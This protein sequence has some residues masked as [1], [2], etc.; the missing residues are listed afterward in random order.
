[1]KVNFK[2]I[3]K[4]LSITIASIILLLIIVIFSLRIPAVQNFAKGHLITFLE[5]KIQTKVT[6][7]KVYVDFP[8]NI[9]IKNLYLQGQDVDTL[10]YVKN[11]DAGLDIWQL[12]KN[13]VDINSIDLDGVR[14]N[15]VRKQDG[16]FNF[17]YIVNAFAAND[18][19]EEKDSKPFIF[20]LDKVKIQNVDVSFIDKQAGNNI[21]VAFNKFDTRVKTF[22]LEKNDYAIGDLI[23]D[24]LKLKL[25][26]DLVKEVAKKVEEKVDSLNQKQPMKIGLKGIQLSNFDID[27]GDD[28]T[29]LFAQLNFK[30]FKTTIKKL[31]LEKN[32]YD[33]GDIDLNGLNLKFNQNLVQDIQNQTNDKVDV[34]STSAPLQLALNKINLKDINVEYG[35]ENVKMYAKVKLNDFNTIIRKLD[36]EQS[37]YQ[38]GDINLDGLDAV[39]N[40]KVVAKKSTVNTSTSKPL[41]IDLNKLNLTNIKVDY[42]DESSRTKAKVDV[43]DLKSKINK[44]DLSN[45]IFDIDH[46][47]LKSGNVNANLH[48]ASSNSNTTSSSSNPISV[49]LKK[50]ILED[51]K[52]NYNNTAVRP[53]N[54]G[55][56]YN[57]LKFSKL[58]V[59]VEYFKMANN[60]FTGSVKKAEIKESKGLNVEQLKT[61]FFY[62]E[63]Q[64]YLKN[65]FLQTPRTLLRDQVILSYQSMKQLTSNPGNIIVDAN[66]KNSKIGFAD[67]LM[68]APT[69]RSTTPFNKY[70]NGILNVDTK[71]NGKVNDF[72]IHHLNVSGLDDLKLTA[73][74]KVLNAMNPDKL[75]FDVNIKNFSTSSKTIYN[76]VPK[77]TIPS[78]I[79]IPS[80]LAVNGKAK[81]STTLVNTQ[82]KMTSTLGN[83][84]LDANIDMRKKDAEKFAVKADLK[85]LDVGTIISN[86]ELGKISGKVNA[87]GTSFNPEKMN[88]E[89]EGLI[90]TATYNKYTYKNVA[91]D[92]KINNGVFNAQI[93]SD[94][95]NANLNLI[96][97]GVYKK[98]ITDV[99]LDGDITK[100]DIQKLGFYSSPMIIK[101][102]INA[103]FANLN[104]DALNGSLYLKDVAISDTKEIFPVQE[105]SLI[106]KATADSNQIN[107]TSQIA[108][109]EI[110]GRF[111]LTQIFGAVAQTI[112]N[113]YNF[114]DNNNAKDK[115][116]PHQYFT[117][118]AKIKDDDLIRKFVPELTNFET[119]T[120]NANYSS[121]DQIIEADATIPN[122]TYG[123]NI[124][125]KGKL[126]I[127]NVNNALVYSLN[128][129][130]I[131]NESF[132]LK[133]IDIE[134]DVANNTIKYKAS[135][136]DDKD[137]IQFLV[138]GNVKLLDDITNISLN[139]DGLV[140]NYNQ[141][142]VKDG[143]L[144][145]L[146]K[147]GIVANNFNISNNGSE[148]SLQSESDKGSSPLNINIK[149]FKIETITELIKKQDLPA[150]GII[151][152]TATIKDLN[153]EMMFNSDL[154]VTELNAF[155]NPVGN[156]VVK[157]Q[158]SSPSVI[159][160]DISL[161]GNNNDLQIKGDYNTKLSE[162]DLLV[163]V[164][165]LEMKTVQ[166]FAMNAIKDTEG[167]ISGKL[168]VKGTLEKPSIL[169]K[170]QFN[171]VGM[172]VA[173]TGSNFRKIS[174]AINFTPKGMELNQ[175]KINDADGNTLTINGNVLTETYR[176]FGFDLTANAR[177]FKVVNS[178][179]SRD[180]MMYGVL[181]VNA[182][183]NIKGNLDLPQVDGTLK[184][185][186][187]T[188]FTFVLPQSSP[189]LEEREGIVEFID[190]DQVELK[191][192]IKTD[193]LTSETKIKGYDVNVNIEIDREAKTSIIIDKA[194]GDFVEI[195][196]EAQLTGGMDPSGKTTLVGVYQVEKGAYELSVSLLKRRFDIQK[197]STI[198]WTGEPTTAQLNITALYKTEAAPIDLIVQQVTG[199]SSSEMNKYKQ[200]IPFNTNLILKG[201]LL[202]PEIKFGITL[203]DDNPTVS[204]SVVDN[205]KAKL[206]QLKNDEAEMNKQVFALLLLNRFI[207]E[208]P[209]KSQSGMSAE[210]IA[211]QSVSNI[212]SQQINNLAADLIK[213][214]DIDF[215]LD[216]QDDYSTG[217]KN[218]RTDLNVA[219][220]KRLLDD[221][222]KVSIGSNF[223][224]EGQAR[225]NENMTNIAGDISV[226]YS[227]SRNGRYMIRAYRKNEY[228]VALQG[229]IIETGVGFIITLDYDE[230]KEIFEKRKRNKEI[231][232]T[233]KAT[234]N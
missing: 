70:P 1:L 210:T 197:G 208:N 205:V 26:Q 182:N 186:D 43:K 170:V 10:L 132:Q 200:R 211:R 167:F 216:S 119:I 5:N 184:V 149:D 172:T 42:N 147:D 215:G 156:L 107:L 221:R 95:P 92:G 229:Q 120:F 44:I 124:I 176:D 148:I 64:A 196:G 202:K 77:N 157:A 8:N 116:E 222:L 100:L 129:G 193:E 232:R 218:T 98:D 75:Y 166:G 122:L 161:T 163:A 35:D 46:I 185:T 68:L 219:V 40:Q 212:L 207:G 231:K 143:N 22:D 57:H 136:K 45:S 181:A 105:M 87:K 113:Y 118:D 3:L 72:T 69:L 187:K 139:P 62:G 23:V 204:S 154:K 131:K 109:A 81:G 7:D 155:G 11:F 47:I 188:N 90:A 20:S 117:L 226:E 227:L 102:V 18:K 93:N 9:E 125:D 21:K 190:Q 74:G 130:A 80:Q 223:G 50:L 58:N 78:N 61:D 199:L 111:K 82:L 137:A 19:E 178:E 160:A 138:G 180:A 203:N 2:K 128:L 151:N 209:F 51:V 49:D 31:D 32:S 224:L 15:V 48:L 195:Q 141:W 27:Y 67:I 106:A 179:K 135:S 220:S 65:L 134:G 233:Q 38:I 159:N 30:S 146:K 73:S 228:Q 140:L 114:Q 4:Y 71:L 63:R 171:E 76:V 52:V 97:S 189:S 83:A 127:D 55:L 123:K 60:S 214:V 191:K 192:T 198:T 13:K 110:K 86:K 39:Y 104:P 145:Q 183:L 126:H 144:I 56:D 152:G 12:L 85:D 175:F 164:N 33:I 96:A 173:Q 115:I 54:Q 36:L 16:T 225:Q 168:D 84:N 59:D 101:G 79:R 94:D 99:K 150:S 206:N 53:T 37:I 201:E 112:N 41:N 88:A 165:R 158:N 162:M 34:K 153:K 28:N 91:L 14:A 66:L 133:K 24:G 142:N 103:N 121:D 108:D 169:G 194:N 6:L 234:E 17:D 230:F 213:G 29:Q 177:N 89:I 217:T 25:K 174:D